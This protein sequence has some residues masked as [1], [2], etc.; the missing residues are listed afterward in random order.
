M[1]SRRTTRSWSRS[2][3][4]WASDFAPT[5]RAAPSSLAERN[6]E[7]DPRALGGRALDLVAPPR[8]QR[9]LPERKQAQVPREIAALG[10][11]EP[12]AVVLDHAEDAAV[13][14]RDPDPDRLGT[15]VTL[16]VGHRL[17]DLAE[18]HRA[19]IDGHLAR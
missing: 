7:L 15:R 3:W 4:P 14:D 10:D 19:E 12:A 2:C 17:G 16:D 8:H 11:D 1:P 9:A 13:V 5:W 18:N 6:P